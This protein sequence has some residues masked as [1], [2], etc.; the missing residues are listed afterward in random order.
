MNEMR[1]LG[2]RL[3]SSDTEKRVAVSAIGSIGKQSE[4]KPKASPGRTPIA[5]GDIY[6]GKVLCAKFV[7]PDFQ[8]RQ[9]HSGITKFRDRRGRDTETG[10]TVLAGEC[11][12]TLDTAI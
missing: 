9:S 10:V 2:T 3:R 5:L 8:G 12:W 4:I 6:M 7:S 11:L 1:T